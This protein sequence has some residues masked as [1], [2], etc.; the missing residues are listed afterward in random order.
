M[1]FVIS[2][3]EWARTHFTLCS[4]LSARLH[5]AQCK[6]SIHNADERRKLSKRIFTS[7]PNKGSLLHL[8]GEATLF[9]SARDGGVVVIRLPSVRALLKNRS[10]IVLSVAD[11]S[12]A[13]L[14]ACD[15]IQVV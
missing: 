8:R 1:A 13:K 11:R 3:A 12:H 15:A 7:L 6:D 14:I 2:Y 4:F 5:G 9:P 10:H